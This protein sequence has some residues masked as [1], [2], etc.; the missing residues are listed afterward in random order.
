MVDYT[1]SLW[2]NIEMESGFRLLAE[3]DF[4]QA[5]A[6]FSKA[7]STPSGNEKVLKL[8]LTACNYW[9]SRIKNFLSSEH[10]EGN[11]LADTLILLKEYQAYSFTQL[12][13]FGTHLLKLLEAGIRKRFSEHTDKNNSTDS[14]MSTDEKTLW[15]LLVDLL[16]SN[17]QLIQ[18][19]PDLLDTLSAHY[20]SASTVHFLRAESY[21]QCRDI[22]QARSIYSYSMLHFPGQIDKTRF[23]PEE[24]RTLLQEHG[25]YMAPVFGTIQGL[26][27]EIQIEPGF[28]PINKQHQ[29]ALD[30]Y[31]Y[32]LLSESSLKHQDLKTATQYRKKLFNTD[33]SSFR[34]YL[35]SLK[36]RE[37][38]LS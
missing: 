1:P 18:N 35:S 32:Y 34:A 28:T 22:K 26:F 31:K 38:R 27:P 16:L 9:G 37:G 14:S 4:E 12:K 30:S 17:S 5:G 13:T 23:I 10:C 7:L 19:A 8:G 24:I 29:I 6:A 20:P 33:Q 36:Q 15:T 11:K 21:Y 25:D 3:L 2:D